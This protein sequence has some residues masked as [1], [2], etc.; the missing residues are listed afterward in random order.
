MAAEPT[1][2]MG[3]AAEADNDRTDT[4]LGRGWRPAAFRPLPGLSGPHRQTVAGRWLRPRGGRWRRERLALAD[5]DFLDLDE[6]ARAPVAPTAVVLLLHGLEGSS[7]S[8]YMVESARLLSARGLLAVALNFRS[9]SGEPNRLPRSYHS[10][11]T[12]DVAHVLG[13]LG[14]RYRRLPIGAIGFSLGGNVLLKYLGERGANLPQGL[15]AACAISVPFDLAASAERLEQGVGRLYGTFFLRALKRSLRAKAE[16]LPGRVPL[17]A[18]VAARTLREFDDAVTAPL[19]GFRDADDY[20]ARS[21]CAPLVEKIRLPTLLLQGADDPIVPPSSFPLAAVRRNPRLVAGLTTAGGHLGFVEPGRRARPGFWAER[22]AVRFLASQLGGR[23]AAA[24]G[25]RAAAGTPRGRAHAGGTSEDAGGQPVP[26]SGAATPPRP[27]PGFPSHRAS[28]ALAAVALLAPGCAPA[29]PQEAARP[30]AG[31]G[32]RLVEVARGLESPVHLVSPPGD[33]R[34]F[35][36]EQAGRIRILTA[37]GPLPR[38]F[39]EIRER[40]RSGGERGL[41]SVA[42]HPRYPENGTFFVNYTDREGDTRVERFRVGT[43]RDAADPGSGK[44]VLR[45]EQPFANH[46]GGHVFF[47]PDGFLY[48]G[49]GDGGA[50]G[51]PRGHGR[52]PRTLLGAMLRL[53]VDGGDPYAVPADNPYAGSGEGRGEVWA[54]GL[55]NPWRSAFDPE[56]RYLYVADVGQNRWEEISV[57]PAGAAGSDF[58]WNVLEGSQCF[59]RP[60]CAR[61]NLVLPAVEYGHDDGCSVTGGHVYRGERL[62]ALR[63]HYFFSDYCAG[64]LRSFRWR[65]GEVSEYRQWEVERAGQVTSFGEDAAGELYVLTA[66]G[67]VLRIEAGPPQETPTR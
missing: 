64:W 48:V 1:G 34:L 38:P 65:E 28:L 24:E 8:G 13:L 66:E 3:R 59:R 44:V 2:T 39:L 35:V 22:E 30:E 37:E 6:P 26:N 27:R 53:D 55:R 14:E 60:R 4:D 50:G 61:E 12:G 25:G 41:L 17:A 57:V 42:F 18:G 63:G 16:R 9:R 56:G 67:R 52:N 46:N 43:E 21:S 23:P 20:Y 31:R 5:G 7:A 32:L 19:H 51:D 54:I 11:E 33:G 45:V 58:G 29:A 40:V 15:R 36:V 10:G 47:G 62:P 49:M